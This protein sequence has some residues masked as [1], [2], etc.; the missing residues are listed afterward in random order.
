MAIIVVGTLP[1]KD[2]G[3]Y[4][5]NVFI[6]DT[7]HLH[8]DVHI[9]RVQGFMQENNLAS[10]VFFGGHVQGKS[11][12]HTRLWRCALWPEINYKHMC[13]TNFQI[14]FLENFFAPFSSVHH[15]CPVIFLPAH[16]GFYPSKWPVDRSL[17]EAMHI[18]QICYCF[19]NMGTNK[20]KVA[21]L[22]LHY[23]FIIYR[24]Y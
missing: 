14:F 2:Q 13:D 1:R 24:H 19:H 3:N 9:S 10:H 23:R 15:L 22:P 8:W 12:I 5:D 21:N 4:N 16:R 7:W 6:I 18:T 20:P 17:H 11:Y